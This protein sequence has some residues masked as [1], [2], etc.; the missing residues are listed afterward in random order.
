MVRDTQLH[1]AWFYL[2]DQQS[3]VDTGN[4]Q[5]LSSVD[6]ALVPAGEAAGVTSAELGEP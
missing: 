2:L 6:S 3:T 4:V 1:K 5:V